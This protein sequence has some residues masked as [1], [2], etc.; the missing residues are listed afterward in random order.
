MR[1]K[2]GQFVQNR[3]VSGKALPSVHGIITLEEERKEI[4]E[5]LWEVL[6]IFIVV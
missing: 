3:V 6:G 4:C 5:R 2:R 1:K